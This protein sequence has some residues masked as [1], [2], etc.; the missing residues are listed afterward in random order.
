LSKLVFRVGVKEAWEAE[1]KKILVFGKFDTSES[2]RARVCLQT[3]AQLYY[4]FSRIL[5]KIKPHPGR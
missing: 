3:L 5:Q 1:L 4:G 2:V